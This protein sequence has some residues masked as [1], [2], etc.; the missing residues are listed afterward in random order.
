[1]DFFKSQQ[2]M[3]RADNHRFYAALQESESGKHKVSREEKDGY[4]PSEEENEESGKS[5]IYGTDTEIVV[6]ADG[7]RVLIVNMKL[8]NTNTVMS[9]EI[10]KPTDLPNGDGQLKEEKSQMNAMEKAAVSEPGTASE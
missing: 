1:M 5:G 6:K 3:K 9:M 2:T 4:V 10:S 8:G 7:S